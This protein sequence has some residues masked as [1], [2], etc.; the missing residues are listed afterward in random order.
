[1]RD[2]IKVSVII[3]VYNSEK[4][5]EK[6][7]ESVC[8]QTLKELEIICIDDGSTDGSAE[9]IRAISLKDDRVRFYTQK[10][11]GVSAARNHGVAISKG[12]FF[13]FLDNDDWLDEEFIEKLFECAEE[14]K[15]DLVTSNVYME[16]INGKKKLVEQPIV[17]NKILNKQEKED[18]FYTFFEKGCCQG[19]VWNSLYRSEVYKNQLFFL[20]REYAGAEDYIFKLHANVVAD[21]QLHI[22]E[23]LYHY[24]VL[25]DSQSHKNDTD[26]RFEYELVNQLI[27]LGN[28]MN[29]NGY[30]GT[31]WVV[32]NMSRHI[33]F[34]VCQFA[35]ELP[36]KKRY[37][38]LKS[39]CNM[40]DIRKNLDYSFIE[41]YAIK[42]KMVFLMIKYKLIALLSIAIVFSKR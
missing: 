29:K 27:Y 40:D 31:R 3:P 21:R 39:I 41:K 2:R 8:N 25:D 30:N 12:Q 34:T 23:G 38:Y 9:L 36:C 6:C 11:Q 1:M 10:N 26:E 16:Y 20:P 35:R 22:Q 14:N 17:Y 42:K 7:I 18:Y 24:R 37:A 13:C 32:Y 4:Y 33:V 5:I 28:L 15:L 19:A